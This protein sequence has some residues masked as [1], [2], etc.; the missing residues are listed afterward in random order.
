MNNS[1]IMI[2]LPSHSSSV[3]SVP[4]NEGNFVKERRGAI[5]VVQIKLI[6]RLVIIINNI[7]LKLY[8]TI[9]CE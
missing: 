3:K 4:S 6:C 8:L 9:G 7:L 2:L 1:E 5:P